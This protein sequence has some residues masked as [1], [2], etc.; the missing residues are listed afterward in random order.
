MATVARGEG[1]KID[2]GRENNRGKPKLG[3]I[4]REGIENLTCVLSS[5]WAPNLFQRRTL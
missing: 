2:I 4:Y 1:E 5:V 3:V